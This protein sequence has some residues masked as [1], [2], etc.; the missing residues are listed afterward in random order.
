VPRST[1]P[2][3]GGVSLLTIQ[4]SNVIALAAAKVADANQAVSVGI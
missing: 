2:R 4:L 3:E 1:K